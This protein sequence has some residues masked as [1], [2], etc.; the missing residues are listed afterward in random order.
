MASKRPFDN[1]IA[2]FFANNLLFVCRRWK[3]ISKIVQVQ[4]N[5]TQTAFV[6][7]RCVAMEAGSMFQVGFNLAM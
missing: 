6:T 7:G 1:V 4:I 3:G 2:W 5:S